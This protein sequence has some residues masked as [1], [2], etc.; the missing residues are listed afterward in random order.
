MLKT[1]FS[2]GSDDSPNFTTPTSSGSQE[3]I[4]VTAAKRNIFLNLIIINE[5]YFL[6]QIHI[7]RIPIRNFQMHIQACI[8]N[9][10]C[11]ILEVNPLPVIALRPEPCSE[12]KRKD[13]VP[14]QR[15]TVTR[16]ENVKQK[17]AFR[18]PRYY[19]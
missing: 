4:Q 15:R 6:I 10:D 14:I 9:R 1:T 8:V 19:Y 13:S 3:L 2:V 7:I 12:I 18:L 17:I 11:R 5:L 16:V